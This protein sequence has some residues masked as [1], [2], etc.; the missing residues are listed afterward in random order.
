M[1]KKLLL[2]GSAIAGLF[3]IV[4]LAIPLLLDANQFRPTLEGNLA[5]ALGRKVTIG[6]L[7]VALLSGGISVDD[8][9]IAD[10]PAFSAAPFLTAKAVN[11]GVEWLPLIFSKQ[12]RV[13]SFRLQD[14]QVV[15]RHSSSGQWNFSSLGT[16]S[17][18]Q[19]GSP[20][21]ASAKGGSPAGGSAAAANVSVQRLTMTGGRVVV[22]GT[23]ESHGKS[24]LYDNVT[25]EATD[26]SDASEFPF[27]LKA[28]TP[29]GG[30][31]SLDGKAGPFNPTDAAQTP[32]HA[33]LVVTHLDLALTGLND[34][35]SGLAGLIDGTADLV[36]DGHRVTSR[37]KLQANK[38]QFVQGGSPARVPVEIDYA[39]DYDLKSQHGVVNQGDVHVGKALAQLTGD[40]N[41]G[42]ETTAVRLKLSGHKMPAPD[43]EATLPAIGVTLPAGASL[44][45][46]TLDAD[47]VISGPLDR[48][49]T[50]GPIDVSNAKVKGFDLS[51]RMGSVAS[52]AGL[53]KSSGTLIQMF[54]STVRIAPDGTRAETLNLV[55]S[56]IG[57]LTGNG[58]IAPNGAL[59][60][61]MLAKLNNSSTVARGVSRYAS[62]GQPDNGIPFRIAGTTANPVF[63]PDVSGVVA[64]VVKNPASATAA[65]GFLGGL[66][67]TKR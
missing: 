52:F 17:T 18:S 66:F 10:D 14:P 30:T 51:S 22:V 12:V 39:S 54:S 48:L 2:T 62:L 5:G 32:F 64:N 49:V 42:G 21:A 63:V 41:T 23:P 44:Q 33:T 59:D 8:I 34:P 38:F 4:V 55:V 13:R 31:V 25:L 53:A 61:T 7:S 6:H 43:L 58:T 24:R 60:F 11:V 15:L 47:L 27:R 1:K 19:S 45:E 37:G 3:V 57:S 16:S 50:T 56:A 20:A 35:A 46:G 9:S 65:A 40:Y 29:G 67:S 28:K 36:S 26:L